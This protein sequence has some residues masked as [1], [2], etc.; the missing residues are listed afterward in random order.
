M[1]SLKRAYL[2]VTRKKGK[3]VLMFAVLLIIATFALT[4]L[5]IGKSS[6]QEQENLRKTLGGEINLAVNYSEDNPYFTIAEM[7]LTDIPD[8]VDQ[9][10][11]SYTQMPITQKEIGTVMGIDGVMAY[12]AQIKDYIMKFANVEYIP[13]TIQLPPTEQRMA[14]QSIVSSTEEVELFRTG[15]LA[16]TQG[17]HFGVDDSNTA[18][19]SKDLAEK[20]GFQLGDTL[21]LQGYNER[22]EDGKLYMSGQTVT[23]V[24]IVGIFEITDPMLKAGSTV[25]TASQH[26]MW[27]NRIFFDMNSFEQWQPGISSGFS[28]ASFRVSDPIKLPDILSY[29]EENSLLD[30]LAFSVG[31]DNEDYTKAAAPLEKLNGLIITILAI[32]SVVSELILSLILAMWARRRIHETGIYL[33]A[34][35]KKAAIIGQYLA[36]VLIIAV[37]AFGLSFFTSSAVAEQVGN[38]LIKRNVQDIQLSEVAVNES[39]A[40]GNDAATGGL[41]VAGG[42]GVQSIAIGEDGGFIISGRRDGF[43]KSSKPLGKVRKLRQKY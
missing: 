40:N 5:A 33:S 26:N 15:A 37:L 38:S 29:M 35:I 14:K 3:S 32:I 12:S 31:I 19:I 23:E 20:N 8:V 17:R 42:S 39:D 4:S 9:G 34:G 24:T 6:E 21:I 1:S 25:S 18:V 10:F 11:T 22:L 16:L 7:I 30:P 27:E 41:F 2:Y 36:E 13:G 28:E 43:R